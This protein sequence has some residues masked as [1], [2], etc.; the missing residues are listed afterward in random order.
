[1]ACIS[2]VRLPVSGLKEIKVPH[3]DATYH[4]YHSGAQ[5]NTGR[6]RVALVLSAAVNTAPLDWAPICPRLGRI[7]LKAVVANIA[8]I[9]VYAPTL[10]AA[11]NIKDDFYADLQDAVDEVPASDISV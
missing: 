11:D 8:I 2:E 7:R 3:A 6:H 4:I 1:M 9:T 10:D 5:D